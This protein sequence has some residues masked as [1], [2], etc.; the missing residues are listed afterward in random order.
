MAPKNIDISTLSK[1]GKIIVEVLEKRF[2]EMKMEMETMKSE[3][4][5]LLNKKNEEINALNQ[6]VDSLKD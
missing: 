3:F 4:S 1:D 6:Q 2:S 5:E